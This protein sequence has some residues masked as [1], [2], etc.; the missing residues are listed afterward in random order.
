MSDSNTQEGIQ[1]GGRQ[2]GGRQEGGRQGG[3][4]LLNT[5]ALTLLK[6]N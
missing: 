5:A 3:Q 2:K 4:C 6:R 1:E